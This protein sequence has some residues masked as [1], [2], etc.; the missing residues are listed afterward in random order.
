MCAGGMASATG[1]LSHLGCER[2]PSKSTLAYQNQH[3]SWEVF[4]DIYSR[5]LEDL[6]PSL[7]KRRLYAARLKRKIFLIDSTVIPL[8]LSVFD[9]AHFRKRK[10]GI[11]LP[12]RP[13]LRHEPPG[14]HQP[15]RGP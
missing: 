8:A 1:N 14:V 15:Q 3:R 11:K 12:H 10:G 7:H 2:A 13:R 5:L 6:E 9:W 4:R